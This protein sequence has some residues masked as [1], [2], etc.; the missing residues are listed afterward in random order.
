MDATYREVLSTGKAVS[1]EIQQLY[2]QTISIEYIPIL[3]R[4]K[5]DGVLISSQDLTQIQKQ[6]AT[7]RKNLS[8]KGLRA[9]YTF[10]D[11][12]HNSDI[13]NLSLIHI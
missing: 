8:D 6:E 3:I 4:E 12:I 9:K 2:D 7:I 10:R 13:M 1:N 5:V 11:I